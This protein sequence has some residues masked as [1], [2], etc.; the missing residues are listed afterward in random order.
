[1]PTGVHQHLTHIFVWYSCDS[2]FTPIPVVQAPQPA[3]VS[4]MPKGDEPYCDL[5]L[6]GSYPNRPNTV[7]AIL[8]MEGNPTCHQLYHMGRT[9]NIPDRL[10]NPLVDFFQAPCG[11]GT[12]S[13]NGGG[14]SN[15][16]ATSASGNSGSV[17][18]RKTP[19]KDSKKKLYSGR[20]RGSQ[21][22]WLAKGGFD[23]YPQE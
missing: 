10:C 9:G 21:T 5:C 7:T 20:Q 8:Y 17:P 4:N 16:G 3:P 14:S 11:C 13:N 15:G 19:P 18:V 6:D 2:S 23:F 1:M 22:R 12:S